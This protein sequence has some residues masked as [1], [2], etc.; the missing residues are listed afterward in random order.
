MGVSDWKVSWTV[1]GEVWNENGFYTFESAQ[2]FARGLVEENG[3]NPG[4]SFS[5]ERMMTVN[6][7]SFLD[8]ESGGAV[9]LAPRLLA[10]A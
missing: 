10:T 4:F 8:A 7:K 3:S 1:N 6:T 2:K 5:A 9:K